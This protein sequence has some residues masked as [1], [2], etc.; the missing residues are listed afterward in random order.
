[1]SV[2]NIFKSCA[3][4]RN[5]C[6]SMWKIAKKFKTCLTFYVRYVRIYNI[7][8]YKSMYM[9][10]LGAKMRIKEGFIVRKIV[11]DYIVVPTGDNIVDF[12]V[13]V[14][15]N[16]SG[17]FLWEALKE[18]TDET[19]LVQTLMQEFEGVDE[20]TAKAD[21]SEFVSMLRENGFLEE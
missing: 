8:V 6:F 4:R 18:E 19:T 7:I 10:I 11:E 9:S 16:E 2:K 20:A 13:T 15:L 14:S 17:A 5:F 3:K 12:A 1:M 21:I